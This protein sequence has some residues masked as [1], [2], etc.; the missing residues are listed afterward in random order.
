MIKFVYFD[1]YQTLLH[2]PG[3]Y[4]GIQQ[5]LMQDGFNVSIDEIILKHKFCSERT[6]FP[7]KTSFEFYEIFNATMISELGISP[8]EKLTSTVFKYC[9]NQ[10]WH[11]FADTDSVNE[12]LVK[13]GIISNWDETLH[14]KIKHFFGG[15][16]T[17][18]IGSAATG[19]SKPG[20]QI[21]T[22][23]IE[24]TGLNANEILY[25]GDSLNFDILPAAN[26]NMNTLLIDRINFYSN[27]KG[28][29]I[30]QLNDIFSFL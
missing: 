2:K 30:S 25:V 27:Y 16:F 15:S 24:K 10:H 13:K 5:A 8:N 21:F 19:F 14:N 9:A 6:A 22:L 20:L 17:H 11:K 12:I 3:V 4:K 23:A 7:A 1:V 18:I 29:K 26:V 28:N